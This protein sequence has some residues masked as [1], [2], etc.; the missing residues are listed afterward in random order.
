MGS[1]HQGKRSE[2]EWFTS[3]ITTTQ[4]GLSDSPINGFFRPFTFLCLQILENNSG[5]TSCCGNVRSCGMPGCISLAKTVAMKL[6]LAHEGDIIYASRRGWEACPFQKCLKKQACV[7]KHPASASTQNISDF[8]C[9]GPDKSE[10]IRA[11]S[12]VHLV[13]ISPANVCLSLLVFN[14]LKLRPRV[15]NSNIWWISS[16]WA[17]ALES[18]RQQRAVG[19]VADQTGYLKDGGDST[20]SCLIVKPWACGPGVALSVIIF[21]EE[22]GIWIGNVTSLFKNV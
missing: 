3:L 22:P 8:Y 16:S 11:L 18:G 10:Q 15:Q 1:P 6:C 7:K 17:A 20:D 13:N 5:E 19:M 21:H 14:L 4:R 12:C 2:E 9:M